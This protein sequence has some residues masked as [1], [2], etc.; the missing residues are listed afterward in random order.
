[1]NRAGLVSSRVRQF[2]A[3]TSKKQL[4][5]VEKMPTGARLV[6]AIV[7]AG[8]AYLAAQLAHSAIEADVRY[9]VR[10]GNMPYIVAAIGV[11]CGWIIMGRRAGEGT[12]FAFS[13]GLLTSVS[14]FF[15]SILVFSIYEMVVLSTK[16]RYKGAT[17]ATID[18]LRI[19]LEH[20]LSVSS[21]QLIALLVFGGFFGGW[22][23][24]WA[25]RRYN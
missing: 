4:R 16:M 1:M 9:E 11:L 13:S 19:A 18:V 3:R 2:T 7:F 5:T 10:V 8:I 15:W 14:I 22:A 23:A 17:E 24:E 6:A 21:P 20:T 25:S 12:R